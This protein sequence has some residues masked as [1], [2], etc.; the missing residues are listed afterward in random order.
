V[1]TDERENHIR[2]SVVVPVF[3]ERENLPELTSRLCSVMRQTKQGFELLFVND[4]STD[5][6]GEFLR[7]YAKGCPEAKVIEFYR[8]FGQHAAV[9][10]G[11]SHTL[12]EIV[13]TLDADLQNPPEEIPKLLVK[14]DEGYEVVCGWRQQRKDSIFR[15][16]PSLIMNLVISKLTGVTLKDYGCMLRAYRRPVVAYLLQYGEKSVYIPA[17]ISWLHPSIIEIP[18]AHARRVKGTSKYSLLKFM[19]QAFDLITAY[20]LFPIQLISITGA[21]FSLLGFLL[22]IYL[23]LFRI[24]WGTPS[25]LTTF[26]AALLFLCG[27]IIFSIGIISEYLAR[28][29]SEVRKKPLY[30]IKK[31]LL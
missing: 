12:G 29:Y 17:F 27:V 13:V 11:F 14:I 28:V 23:L 4:G 15:R 26:I 16:L 7:E 21:A 10:A 19:I 18:V 24:F 2:V 3:N 8:N 22:S 1:G 31:N 5:D 20:T 9:M 25:P 6:S 30:I